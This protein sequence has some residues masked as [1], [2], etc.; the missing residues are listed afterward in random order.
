MQELEE[1][2]NKNDFEDEYAHVDEQHLRAPSRAE[3]KL[4]AI[5][6]STP[7][8]KRKKIFSREWE[9]SALVKETEQRRTLKVGELPAQGE[10]VFVSRYLF[11][12]G[13]MIIFP[14]PFAGDGIN[15][16]VVL[17]GLNSKKH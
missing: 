5:E 14:S 3:R 11:S 6:F 10:L 7:P 4:R 13:G 15:L 12:L 17:S 16:E 1:E 2:G 9:N 8:T